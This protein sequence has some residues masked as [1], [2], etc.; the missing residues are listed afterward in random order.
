MGEK[1]LSIGANSAMAL[2]FAEIRRR[3]I[4]AERFLFV[5]KDGFK[6]F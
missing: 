4:F 2:H 1:T 5:V 6:R 3:G